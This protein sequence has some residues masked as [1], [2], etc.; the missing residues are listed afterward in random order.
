MTDPT[1]EQW[2]DLRARITDAVIGWTLSV[3]AAI[4]DDEIDYV[5]DEAIHAIHDA[6]REA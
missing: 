4:V 1:R 2:A 3:G 6:L 5:A